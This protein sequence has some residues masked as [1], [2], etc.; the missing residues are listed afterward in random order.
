M[1]DDCHTR[2]REKLEF[3]VVSENYGNVVRYLI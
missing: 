1:R 2:P 3:D